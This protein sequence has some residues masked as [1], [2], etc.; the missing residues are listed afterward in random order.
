MG[1]VLLIG[2]VYYVGVRLG[3]L[4]VIN[5]GHG[6]GDGMSGMRGVRVR[7]LF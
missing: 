4:F 7:A 2:M 1:G 6:V 5:G 3:V